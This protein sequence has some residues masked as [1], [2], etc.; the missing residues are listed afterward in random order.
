MR[1]KSKLPLKIQSEHGQLRQT[2]LITAASQSKGKQSLGI[3]WLVEAV[4]HV[5]WPIKKSSREKPMKS[6]I[7]IDFKFL[8]AVCG[9]RW[10][11]VM[12]LIYKTM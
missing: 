2:K 10:F 1:L 6:L 4:T 11:Y 7:T 5:F 8:L 9:I 3:I 12:T